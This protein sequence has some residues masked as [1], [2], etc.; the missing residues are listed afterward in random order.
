MKNYSTRTGGKSLPYSRLKVVT[1]ALIHG[2]TP[3]ATTDKIR[4]PNGYSY[5]LQTAKHELAHTVRHSLVS[6]HT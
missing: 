6:I 3:Y 2:G 4:I 5:N 1:E